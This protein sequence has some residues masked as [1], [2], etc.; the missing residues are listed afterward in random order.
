MS[1][2]EAKLYATEEDVQKAWLEWSKFRTCFRCQKAFNWLDSYG[3]HECRQHLGGVSYKMCINVD[4]FKRRDYRYWDCCKK[5]PF[6]AIRNINDTIW[7]QFRQTRPIIH[8]FPT[9]DEIPGCV[10]CDHSEASHILDDGIRLNMSAESPY[11]SFAPLG[12]HTVND[13]VIYLGENR[14]V[15]QV[16]YDK[17]V[18]LAD[19]D[20]GRIPADK[21]I[22]PDVKWK[23]KKGN[24]VNWNFKNTPIPI[25]ILKRTIV[26]PY[27]KQKVKI[28]F[29]IKNIG[30]AVHDIAAMIPHMSGNPEERPGWQ[31]DKVDGKVMFPY[32]KN[33][34]RRAPYNI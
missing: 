17:S 32:I 13:E 27:G 18:D 8:T 16:Y 1:L 5:K 2:P 10:P 4:G 12:G 3:S 19:V 20:Q 7:S 14:I 15:E 24:Y 26:E 30:M 21:L 25:K 22:W 29:E 28:D 9:A 33:T 31:F 34:A 11:Y 6:T 23:L